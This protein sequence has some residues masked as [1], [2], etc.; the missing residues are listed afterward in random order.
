MEM[1]ILLS[2]IL[3][4]AGFILLIVLVRRKGNDSFLNELANIIAQHLSIYP[5]RSVRVIE[6]AVTNE[7]GPAA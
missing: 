4:F 7:G 5:A 2:S 3:S 6:K 1:L